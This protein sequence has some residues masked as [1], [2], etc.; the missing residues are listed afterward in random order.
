MFTNNNSETV[1]K[2][3]VDQSVAAFTNFEL[4][5]ISNNDLSYVDTLKYAT[6]LETLEL[7]FNLTEEDKQN[8]DKRNQF[9][10]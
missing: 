1:P 9:I 6:K 7:G 4:K 8:P 3:Y 2:D 10:E 5:K